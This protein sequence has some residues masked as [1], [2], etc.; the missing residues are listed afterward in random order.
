M[1][2]QLLG[3]SRQ[4]LWSWKRA[5]VTPPRAMG[6]P[7]HEVSSVRACSCAVRR[8]MR[9]E[10]DG[11]MGGERAWRMLGERYP[12]R[13]VRICVKTWKAR[14]GVRARRRV[15]S[16]RVSVQVDVRDAAWTIDGTQVGRDGAGKKQALEL[17]RELRS[18]GYLPAEVGGPQCGSDVIAVLEAGRRAR[19]CLPLVVITDNGPEN[20]NAEVAAYFRRHRIVHMRSAPHVPQHNGWAERGVR[21]VKDAM[22]CAAS[23]VCTRAELQARANAAI[24]RLNERRLRGS[25]GWQTSAEITAAEPPAEVLVDRSL[26]YVAACSAA[27]EAV[28]DLENGRAKRMAERSAIL[29]TMERFCLIRL[30][31]GRNPLAWS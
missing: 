4:T 13:L 29:Q 10:A 12:L 14:D 30:T 17:G 20:V 9:M 25:R 3:V 2:A 19:G 1:I 26:F 22:R 21:E 7:R 18:L 8:V 15:M 23:V 27:E 16:N 28:R 5:A 11:A 6:R 31:R 24:A